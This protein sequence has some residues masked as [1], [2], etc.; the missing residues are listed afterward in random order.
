MTNRSFYDG[1]QKLDDTVYMIK[2]L[3]G[4]AVLPLKTGEVN[5]YR[6]ARREQEA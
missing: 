1:M 3:D 5:I 2:R 4:A 6:T